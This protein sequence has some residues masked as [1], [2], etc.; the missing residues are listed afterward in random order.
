MA[1]HPSSPP[2]D[3]FSPVNLQKVSDEIRFD[4]YDEVVVD[5]LQVRV[6]QL[7][8]YIHV[9]LWVDTQHTMPLYYLIVCVCRMSVIVSQMCTRDWKSDGSAPFPFHSVPSTAEQG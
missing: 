7:M 6:G 9:L 8:L 2:G 1:I 5:L 4:L 3:D